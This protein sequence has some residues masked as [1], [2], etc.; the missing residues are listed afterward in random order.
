MAVAR[1]HRMKELADLYLCPTVLSEY[2]TADLP[3]IPPTVAGSDPSSQN[4]QNFH[5][6]QSPGMPSQLE[7]QDNFYTCFYQAVSALLLL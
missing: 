5:F 6:D 4:G 2:D 7:D 3:Y 1:W